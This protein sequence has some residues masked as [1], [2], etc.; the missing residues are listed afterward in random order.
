MET[1]KSYPLIHTVRPR[2]LGD[3]WKSLRARLREAELSTFRQNSSPGF[4][5]NFVDK[6][7]TLASS[8]LKNDRAGNVGDMWI[9]YSLIH[10]P[11]GPLFPKALHAA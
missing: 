10:T 6:W 8:W 11:G 5:K 2:Y 4:F 7:I 9:S 1:L 3:M